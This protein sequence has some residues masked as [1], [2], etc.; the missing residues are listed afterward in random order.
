MDAGS[1]LKIRLMN[2]EIDCLYLWKS[3]SMFEPESPYVLGAKE[4]MAGYTR[5]DWVSMSQEATTMMEDMGYIVK[6]NLG[7]FTED[8][9]DTLCSHLQNW[10]FEVDKALIDRFAIF[11]IS[12]PEYVL[13][14]NKYGDGL[15]LYFYRMC[16]KYSYKLAGTK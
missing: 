16:Q 1:E 5:E 12:V 7:E 4:K 2:K 15:N 8:I 11:S 3:W 10:F 14:L 13:F 9:F 6:N